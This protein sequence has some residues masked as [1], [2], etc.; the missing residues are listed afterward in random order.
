MNK[1][2]LFYK[3]Y[4]VLCQF[5]DENGRSTLKDYIPIPNI[6]SVGRLDRDSEG[7]LL[8]TDNGQL[9]HR[10]GHR[11]FAHPRTYWVQVERIPDLNALEKLRQGLHIQDYRTRPAIVN[12]LDFEPDLP[13]REPAI[14]YRKSVPTAWLEITL[15]EGRNRQVRRM[16]AAVGYPTLRLIRTAITIDKNNKLCLTGLQPNQWRE[17]TEKERKALEKL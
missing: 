2:I 14:R 11:Q 12:L 5:T 9:Q 16:T 1:Y 13:P 17:V 8:L 3:P 15:T 4:D 10:L 7:L 6:Y